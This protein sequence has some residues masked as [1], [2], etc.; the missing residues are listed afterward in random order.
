[1]FQF[2]FSCHLSI[3]NE[4]TAYLKA[5]LLEVIKLVELR[6]LLH[7]VLNVYKKSK[8][9]SECKEGERKG[10]DAVLEIIISKMR[11]RILIWYTAAMVVA[12]VAAALCGNQRYSQF[13]DFLSDIV[14][15]WSE[16]HNSFI[17]NVK[18]SRHNNGDSIVFYVNKHFEPTE[19][20]SS[21]GNVNGNVILLLLLFTC[22]AFSRAITKKSDKL[23]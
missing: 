9:D 21:T 18:F 4:Y 20:S 11:R 1:M 7:Y 5:K 16:C 13:V 6:W 3:I 14:I 19:S 15:Q 8:R 23:H 17:R 10:R 12:M 2:N 22:L